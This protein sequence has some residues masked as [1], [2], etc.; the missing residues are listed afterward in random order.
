M[1]MQTLLE[2]NLKN[3]IVKS[4]YKDEAGAM[5]KF[6]MKKKWPRIN[7]KIIFKNCVLIL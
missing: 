4:E 6:C 3:N 7:D 2:L 1:C 5:K